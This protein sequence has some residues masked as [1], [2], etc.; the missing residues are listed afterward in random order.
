MGFIRGYEKNTSIPHPSPE[1]VESFEELIKIS[2]RTQEALLARVSYLEARI[3]QVLHD[4]S[5]LHAEDKSLLSQFKDLERKLQLG[6]PHI[7]PK[8]NVS[9]KTTYKKMAGCQPH[10]L[11]GV[12]HKKPQH[13][14]YYYYYYYHHHPFP[15][16]H[17]V[18]HP[19]ARNGPRPSRH[20]SKQDSCSPK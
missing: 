7:S 11:D 16:P 20:N 8:L 9:V 1:R 13:P 3:S 12:Q 2:Q 5:S 4:Y 6:E 10:E 15:Q 17:N 14:Y 18:P 19:L